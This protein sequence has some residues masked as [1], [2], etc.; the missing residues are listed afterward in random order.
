MV[1]LVN[2]N[3]Q[4]SW[5][6]F[7]HFVLPWAIN[8]RVVMNLSFLWK[9]AADFQFL[10]LE[11][12]EKV[13]GK[14]WKSP[15]IVL[16]CGCMNPEQR[17]RWWWDPTAIGGRWTDVTWFGFHCYSGSAKE[18]WLGL[19]NDSPTSY[20]FHEVGVK[21]FVAISACQAGHSHLFLGPEMIDQVSWIWLMQQ[22]MYVSK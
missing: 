12:G 14:S 3:L 5:Q 10:V 15:G 7:I 6:D 1:R 2:G 13:L 20:Q 19:F 18:K 4:I 8:L 16:G 11:N 17:K 9:S 22:T 21:C